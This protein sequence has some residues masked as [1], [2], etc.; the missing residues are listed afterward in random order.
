MAK[1]VTFKIQNN[2]ADESTR[3]LEFGPFGDGVINSETLRTNA[4][5][6]DVD[7]ISNTYLSDSGAKFTGIGG[8]TIFETDEREI[9]LN[10]GE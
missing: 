4:K 9:N 7:A 1:T 3:N 8:V 6:F 5:T 2:F 10:T